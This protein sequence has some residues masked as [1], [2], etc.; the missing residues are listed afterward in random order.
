MYYY[1]TRVNLERKVMSA[2]QGGGVVEWTTR[3][4]HPAT[5]CSHRLT[6]HRPAVELCLPLLSILLTGC[7]YRLVKPEVNAHTASTGSASQRQ[8]TSLLLLLSSLWAFGFAVQLWA[9]LHSCHHV[10]TAAVQPM[11]VTS[12]KI[13]SKSPRPR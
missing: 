8:P 3:A 6:D 5:F 10:A 13:V 11:L 4:G 7:R 12:C 9:V 2:V 1:C